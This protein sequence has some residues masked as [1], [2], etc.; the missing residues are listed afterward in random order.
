MSKSTHDTISA[1]ELARNVALSIDR[2]RLSGRSLHITKGSQTVAE[3]CPPPK[4][5][6]SLARLADILKALPKLGDDAST[7]A[8]DLKNARRH[9]QLPGNAWD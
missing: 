3:L 1:T 7:F 9:A 6:V 5:G 8:N 4:F 2:V